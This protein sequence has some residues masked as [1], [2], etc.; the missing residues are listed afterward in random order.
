MKLVYV[1][2]GRVVMSRLVILLFGDGWEKRQNLAVNSTHICFLQI[3]QL[4]CLKTSL[5]ET[6][7]I[8]VVCQDRVLKKNGEAVLG[9]FPKKPSSMVFITNIQNLKYPTSPFTILKLENPSHDVPELHKI[10][11]STDLEPLKLGKCSS[12]GANTTNN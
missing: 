5:W 8:H 6:C 12:G 2:E 9:Y 7:D 1:F 4:C 11:R 10:R 3:R